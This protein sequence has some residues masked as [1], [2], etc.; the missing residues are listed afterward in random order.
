VSERD[1]RLRGLAALALRN[2]ALVYR[3][4]GRD[5]DEYATYDEII[6]RFAGDPNAE[7]YRVRIAVGEA[8]L[9]KGGRLHQAENYRGA[10]AAGVEG[11]LYLSGV[12]GPEAQQTLARLLVN[13]ALSQIRLLDVR[14]ARMTLDDLENR[15]VDS[16]DA[17]IS[18]QLRKANEI[19]S[20]LLGTS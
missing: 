9:M 19:R 14:G 13:V 2:K 1:P 3:T 12:K 20:D 5:T 17:V 18:E 8:Y 6:A 7:G 16:S 15:F 4:R 11:Q 10:V